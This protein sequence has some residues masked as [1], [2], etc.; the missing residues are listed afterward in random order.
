MKAM[1]R[2]PPHLI[3]LS[4]EEHLFLESLIRTG[5]TEQRVARRARILL[6]MACAETVV[7]Q[8]AEHLEVRRNTIWQVCRRYEAV[9][10]E[11]VFD[12]PRVGRPWTIFPSA[13]GG[14]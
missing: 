10:V 9:G 7:Q 13:T 6:A 5:R 12:A 14:N 8:L 1:R 11:A 2:R 3:E 4:P